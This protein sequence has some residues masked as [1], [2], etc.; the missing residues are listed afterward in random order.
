MTRWLTHNF[1]TMYESYV[2]SRS[3]LS[4]IV[5]VSSYILCKRFC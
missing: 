5:E 4:R 1:C 2:C 3:Q